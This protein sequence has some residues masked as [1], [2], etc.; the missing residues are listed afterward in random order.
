MNCWLFI[1]CWGNDAQRFIFDKLRSHV[2]FKVELAQVQGYKQ[3]VARIR[4]P[5]S[6]V[7]KVAYREDSGKFSSDIS[8]AILLLQNDN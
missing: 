3:N 1:V 7:I 6:S 8:K 4:K 5:L 2:D